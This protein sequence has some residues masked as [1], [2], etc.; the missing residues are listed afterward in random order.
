MPKKHTTTSSHVIGIKKINL[1]TVAI[2]FF[3][4]GKCTVMYIFFTDEEIKKTLINSAQILFL[5]SHETKTWL[6]RNLHFVTLLM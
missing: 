3:I 1:L 6:K 5:T 2:Q 4:L